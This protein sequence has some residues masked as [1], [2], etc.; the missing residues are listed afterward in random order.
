MAALLNPHQAQDVGS[1][2]I[3]V[4]GNLVC[5]LEN[6]TWTANKATGDVRGLCRPG[7][8]NQRLSRTGTISA[9]A[10]GNSTSGFANTDVDLTALSIGGQTVLPQTYSLSISGAFDKA[11]LPS[12]G[13]SGTAMGVTGQ[14]YNGSV[15]M[16]IDDNDIVQALVIASEVADE[17][18]AQ[19]VFTMTLNGTVITFPVMLNGNTHA[20]TQAQYQ[21]IT[22]PFVSQAPARGTA[23]PTSPS[24]NLPGSPGL[25]DYALLS[26]RTNLSFDF[27]S[28]ATHGV[29]RQGF[30]TWTSFTIGVSDGAITDFTYNWDT[31][32]DWTTTLYNAS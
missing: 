21:R 13:T 32:G 12:I 24:G 1:L 28:K 20:F 4:G 27:I 16:Q 2:I 15:E 22:I 31:Y 10:F 7:A 14:N 9:K 11:A 3:Q 6:A 29:R 19:V 30:I 18:Q 17:T 23:F 8:L 26:P 5:A 25:L